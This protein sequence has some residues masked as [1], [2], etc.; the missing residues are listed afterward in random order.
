MTK[1]DIYKQIKTEDKTI[2]LQENLLT[3]FDKLLKTENIT[4]NKKQKLA[5]LRAKIE[6]TLTELWH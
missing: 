6:I 1:I 5:G 2:D 4:K 3:L